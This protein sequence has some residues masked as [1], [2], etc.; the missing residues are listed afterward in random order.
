MAAILDL[1]VNK[2]LKVTNGFRKE[3]SIKKSCGNE[4]LHQNICSLVQEL[5]FQHSA[6]RPFCIL[7]KKKCLVQG[8]PCDFL[9][10]LK[11]DILVVYRFKSLYVYQILMTMTCSQLNIKWQPSWIYSLTKP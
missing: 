9:Q 7:S 11:E 8:K 6:W 10:V 1:F 4:V 3:F 5:Q 2:N